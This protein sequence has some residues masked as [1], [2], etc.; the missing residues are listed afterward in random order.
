MSEQDTPITAL[1][2]RLLNGAPTTKEE[3]LALVAAAQAQ[4]DALKNEVERLKNENS[5]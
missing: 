4:L 5:K 2:D 3:R 1:V